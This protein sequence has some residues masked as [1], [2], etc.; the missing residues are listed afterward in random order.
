[1]RTICTSE[2]EP[3]MR[4]TVDGGLAVRLTNK[5]GAASVKGT[6][7]A[8]SPSTADAFGLVGADQSNPVG[9]VLESGISDGSP[10]WIGVTG[11]MQMLLQDSSAASLGY[12]IKVSDT[13]DGRVDAT[14]LLPTGGTIVALEDHLTECGHSL[15]AVTAGTDKLAWTL[16]H[17]N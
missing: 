4:F 15:E 16:A 13:T 1:M 5:T 14:N 2:G 6:A 7:V 9:F 12:W 8:V 17:F 10:C 3:R 11:R